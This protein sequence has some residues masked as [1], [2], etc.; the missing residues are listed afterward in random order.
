MA[1][2]YLFVYG[3]LKKGFRNKA[4]MEL[5]KNSSFAGD[6][7][8]NGRLFLIEDYPGAAKS[9]AGNKKDIIYGELYRIRNQR[10]LFSILD[11]FEEC[12]KR[13]PE[14]TLFKREICKVNTEAGRQ[15]MAWVYIYNRETAGLQQ[16]KPGVFAKGASSQQS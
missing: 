4:R 5:R 16:I 12:S 1:P 3:S 15:I 8:L 6:A 11:E 9:K 10:H 13:F 2:Q 14:P 7:M